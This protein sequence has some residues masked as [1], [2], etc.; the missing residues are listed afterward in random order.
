MSPLKSTLGKIEQVPDRHTAGSCC[1]NNF[2]GVAWSY[3]WSGALR[4]GLALARR[5][6]TVCKQD[7][8]T[9]QAN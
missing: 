6:Y 4:T 5:D 8:F 9:E 1:W 7:G 2:I 3:A